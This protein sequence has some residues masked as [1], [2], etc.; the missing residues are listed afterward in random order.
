MLPKNNKTELPTS[1]E[2]TEQELK[3]ISAGG[4]V[5]IVGGGRGYGFWGGGWGRGFARGYA[6]GFGRGRR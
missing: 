3:Q 4:K 1:A 6:R 2:L 5:L